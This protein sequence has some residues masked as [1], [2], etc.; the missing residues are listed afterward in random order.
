MVLGRIDQQVRDSYPNAGPNRTVLPAVPVRPGTVDA[1]VV[2]EFLRLD[3]W[4][5]VPD[6]G[7]APAWA[8]AVEPLPDGHLMPELTPTGP[9]LTIMKKLAFRLFRVPVEGYRRRVLE[10]R[11]CCQRLRASGETRA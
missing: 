10:S 4:A 11:C 3:L 6:Q 2:G 7:V 8:L 9:Q 1:A 5:V